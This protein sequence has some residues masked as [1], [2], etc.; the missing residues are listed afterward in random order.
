MTPLRAAVVGCGPRGLE[1]AAALRSLEGAE[2]VGLAELEPA[3]R[4]RVVDELGMP[5]TG[6]ALLPA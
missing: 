2:P 6:V 1:H 3:P 4:R 5:V